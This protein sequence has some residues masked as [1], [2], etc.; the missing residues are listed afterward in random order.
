MGS[1][2]RCILRCKTQ[3][4]NECRS[5]FHCHIAVSDMAPEFHVKKITGG[6]G[7]QTHL[8]LSSA[9]PFMDAGHPL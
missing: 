3:M 1:T 2:N 5:S 6:G 4:N 9:F 7:E 8:S